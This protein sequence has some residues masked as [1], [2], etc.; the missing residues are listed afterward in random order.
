MLAPRP[1]VLRRAHA[2]SALALGLA[3]ALPACSKSDAPTPPEKGAAANT[4]APAIA[5]DYGVDLANKVITLGALNDESGPAA[6]LGKPYAVGKRILAAQVNAGGSGILP[7]GWKI[8]L[9]ERDHQYNPQKSVQAYN[10]IKDQVLFIATSFGTPNTLP[11]R[12]MLARDHIVAFPASLSSAMAA[13]PNTPPIGPNYRVEAMRAMDFAV[14]QAGGADAVKA[15]I[16]Y[17]KDDY[18]QDGLEGW[19]AAAEAAGVTI[20]AQSTVAPGQ[21][22]YT[23]VVTALKDA[24]ATHVLLTVLASATGP[25]L[26]SAAQLGYQPT[27]LANTPAWIDRF[28]DPSVIP[29]TVF[30][31]FYFVS[32]LSYWNEDLPGMKDFLAAYEAYGK[33]LHPPDLYILGS[34]VQGRV[35]LEAFR[36]ALE[37]GD[38]TRPAYLEALQ[39]IADYDGGG[40]IQPISLTQ[41][42]YATSVLTRV[43]APDFEARSWTE[44]APYAVPTAMSPPQTAA[45]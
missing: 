21:K 16:V 43:L 6:A 17:Q 31:N 29:P 19:T 24:G 40:L 3:L 14:E 26:G 38:V 34:Y 15:A 11:L 18:G 9:V 13:H 22:D 2:V 12:D 45:E 33:D 25:I 7:E 35:A 10:A 32:G 36:R 41:Q 27:W 37:A 5:T 1:C 30:K 39:S 23:A 20:V 28:Y 44:A 42:P 8:E 4:G